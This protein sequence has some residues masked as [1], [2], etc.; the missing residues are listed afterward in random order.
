[1]LSKTTIRAELAEPVVVAEFW[2][3]RS[4]TAVR[5]QLREFEGLAVID[6]R[7]HYTA[8]N[9]KGLLADTGARP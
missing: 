1:M 2:A 9:G 5:I 3:N 7:K 4:D 8:A 6:V